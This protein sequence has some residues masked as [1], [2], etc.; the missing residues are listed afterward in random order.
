MARSPESTLRTDMARSKLAHSDAL[1]C[2]AASPVRRVSILRSRRAADPG[3][4]A[5]TLFACAHTELQ[6][7]RAHIGAAAFTTRMGGCAHHH[8]LP[9]DTNTLIAEMRSP[10]AP[11]S[12]VWATLRDHPMAFTARSAVLSFS[13]HAHP[14][15]ACSQG[16]RG[17]TSVARV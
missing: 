3:A 17:L 11:R 13:R 16:T 1:A 6:V 12:I 10:Q 5:S 2:R 4:N 14:L 8:R 15:Q 7:A 9:D